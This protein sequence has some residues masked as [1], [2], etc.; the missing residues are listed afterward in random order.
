MEIKPC[1]FCGGTARLSSR[2]LRFSG[3]R[4]NYSCGGGSREHI[5]D[6][7]YQVICNRCKARGPLFVRRGWTVEEIRDGRSTPSE[8]EQA[9]E[10]WNWRV[11]DDQK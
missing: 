3:Y 8:I 4:D 7:A 6:M 5:V 9:V 10:A 11:G 1:P 2:Q